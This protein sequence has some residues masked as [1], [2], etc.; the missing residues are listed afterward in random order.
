MLLYVEDDFL[1]QETMVA[2]LSDAGYHVLVADNGQ[3]ARHQIAAHGAELGVLVTDIN[4]GDGPDGWQVAREARAQYATL[5]I[6]YV[7][8]ASEHH[9][10]SMGVPGSV[11]IAKPFATAEVVGAISALI[12]AGARPA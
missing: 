11:M 5:P 10:A 6:V 7:S 9:W 3:Q 12:A 8:A 4:L 2:A 1:I